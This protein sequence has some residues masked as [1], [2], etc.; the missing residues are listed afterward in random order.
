MVSITIMMFS[1]AIRRCRDCGSNSKVAWGYAVLAILS[2]SM[3]LSFES[4]SLYLLVL[5][6]MTLGIW[7]YSKPSKGRNRYT[8]GYF[9]PID[10]AAVAHD[11]LTE[12]KSISSRIEPSLFGETDNDAYENS[13]INVNATAQF[14]NQRAEN[15]QATSSE[16]ESNNHHP[17][18]KLLNEW[19]L[20]NRMLAI[21]CAIG[22]TLLVVILSL[23]PLILPS[24]SEQSIEQVTQLSNQQP[25]TVVERTN[26]LEM[27][28]DFYLLLDS[29]DV[30]ILHWKA[31]LIKTGEIWSLATAKG[32]E[33]CS[34]IEFNKGDTV[35]TTSVV[36]EGKGSYYANF[37]P[38]DAE[39][40]VKL[41]A[42][43]GSFGLCGYNFSLKGSQKALN[44][45]PMYSDLAN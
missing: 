30:L 44:S 32:D 2:F 42:K 15:T 8:L 24:E 41:L 19:L 13:G 7:L 34:V 23:L 4:L 18:A 29:N 28:D 43:R 40:V 6:P 31:D 5:L 1:T 14:D 33:T 11:P 9:G 25:I 12:T 16:I 26:L 17:F 21:A 3:I 20:S 35:R 22:V 38:L 45:N 27:P 36:V 37:S 10:L 39:K